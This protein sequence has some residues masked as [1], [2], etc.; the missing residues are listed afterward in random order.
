MGLESFKEEKPSCLCLPTRS[1]LLYLQRRLKTN[2]YQILL[3]PVKGRR[4]ISSPNDPN[5][6]WDTRS[7]ILK[8]HRRSLPEV[9]SLDS[10]I[11]H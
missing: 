8:G 3:I 9:K 2:K 7:L 6:L 11:N 10:E 4:L 1:E 5:R